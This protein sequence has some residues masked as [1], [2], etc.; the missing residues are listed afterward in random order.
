MQQT[1]LLSMG[2][3]GCLF[4]YIFNQM[5]RLGFLI[6]CYA[7]TKKDNNKRKKN[8]HLNKKTQS[9]NLSS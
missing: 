8:K 1:A 3:V 7:G 4:W 5:A 9:K 2:W 6:V